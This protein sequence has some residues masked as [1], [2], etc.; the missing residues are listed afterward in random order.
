MVSNQAAWLVGLNKPLEVGDSEM[1]K[2]AA[3]EVV[4]RNCAIAINPVDWKNQEGHYLYEVSLPF[5]FGTD[6]AGE[7]H[8]VGSAVKGFKK[9]DRVLA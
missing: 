9:G 4:V 5:V 2:P 3:D 6:V 7:I 1:P 8:E